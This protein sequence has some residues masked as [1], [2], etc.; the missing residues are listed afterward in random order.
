MSNAEGKARLHLASRVRE[1]ESVD[2]EIAMTYETPLEVTQSGRYVKIVFT[3]GGPH[4]EVLLELEDEFEYYETEA[5]GGFATFLNWN[6]SDVCLI[7]PYDARTILHA[8]WR[9]P[10]DLGEDA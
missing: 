3:T 4:F 8:I 1:A 9:E 6:E 10:D 2:P 5:S 7:G